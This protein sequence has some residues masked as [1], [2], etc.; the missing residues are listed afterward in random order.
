MITATI[1]TK[2]QKFVGLL[3]LLSEVESIWSIEIV[4]A[5]EYNSWRKLGNLF[6]GGFTWEDINARQLLLSAVSA[7]ALAPYKLHKILNFC[8]R[9]FN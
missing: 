5:S 6:H 1:I 3:Q 4:F 8:I 9:E 7:G 2:V